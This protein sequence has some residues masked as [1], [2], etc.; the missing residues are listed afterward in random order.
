VG[1]GA[2]DPR[3]DHA[4]HAHPVRRGGEGGCAGAPGVASLGS[5]LWK[6]DGRTRSLD[7]MKAMEIAG[8]SRSINQERVQ[9]FI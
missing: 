7:T 3:L 5:G 1:E 8:N 9:E 2:K 6:R 4:V